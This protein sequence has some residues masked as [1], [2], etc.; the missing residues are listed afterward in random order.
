MFGLDRI[1]VSDRIRLNP[2][3]I[4]IH[5]KESDFIHIHIHYLVNGF[6]YCLT[7]SDRV[8]NPRIRRHFPSLLVAPLSFLTKNHYF[9]YFLSSNMDLFFNKVV[10]F[11]INLGLTLFFFGFL[12]YLSSTC[13][14][15]FCRQ[16]VVTSSYV[17]KG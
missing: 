5:S 4:H 14:R 15:M 7:G 8:G 3:P 6:F 12:C 17:A 10:F 1:R 13:Y 16:L 2:Y 9:H 11:Y